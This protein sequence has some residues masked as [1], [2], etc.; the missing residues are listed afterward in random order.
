MNSVKEYILLLSLFVIF[1]TRKSNMFAKDTSQIKLITEKKIT[2]AIYHLNNMC[3][4]MPSAMS[5]KVVHIYVT[6]KD[7][8]ISIFMQFAN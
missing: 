3:L 7:M 8:L 6:C 4:A 2:S 5:T 1:D